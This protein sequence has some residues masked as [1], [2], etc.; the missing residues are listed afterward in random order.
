MK[1]ALVSFLFAVLSA[2]GAF[3]Q[4]T[5]GLAGISGVVRDGTGAVVP[6][7]Q[8]TVANE[9]RGVRLTLSTSDGGVFSTPPLVP[10]DGYSV[11]VIKAGFSPYEVKDISLQVGQNVNLTATLAVAG[12]ATEIRVEAS[13]PL[14]DEL[15]TDVSQVIIHS[16]SLTCPL[17]AGESTPSCC[18]RPQ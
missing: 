7:A 4:A 16:K 13:A 15:K 8:V 11:S 5:V 2:G 14:V 9:A 12:T 18:S 1:K 10:A 3:A 17:T 6:G